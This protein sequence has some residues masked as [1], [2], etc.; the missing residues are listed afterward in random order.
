VALL[1]QLVG[2]VLLRHAGFPPRKH[3]FR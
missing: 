3:V 1:V 2:N